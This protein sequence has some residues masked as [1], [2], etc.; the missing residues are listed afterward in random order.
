MRKF[1]FIAEREYALE[2]V[3]SPV[4][5]KVYPENFHLGKGF[6]ILDYEDCTFFRHEWEEVFEEE[7]TTSA[8]SDDDKK[9]V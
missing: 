5:G 1:R 3:N 4:T 8:C 7:E 6:N 2:Y 9:A